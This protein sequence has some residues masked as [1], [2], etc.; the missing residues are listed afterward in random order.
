[1]ALE[2]K[3]QLIDTTLTPVE[4]QRIEHDLA[5]LERRLARYPEATATLVLRTRQAPRQVEAD[6]QVYLTPGGTHLIS[7]QSAMSAD[8]AVAL[9]SSD[10]LRGYERHRATVTH[11]ATY[12]V[13]SR[14]EPREHR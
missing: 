1:M 14:R 13:P 11:E 4:E 3:I 6:L 9:A 12:G 10:V 8:R 7:H 5:G 2:R